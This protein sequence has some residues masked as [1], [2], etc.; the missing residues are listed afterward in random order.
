ML[1]QQ[2][3]DR[4]VVLKGL[5]PS[6]ALHRQTDHLLEEY[7]ARV[8]VTRFGF[9]RIQRCFQSSEFHLGHGE[10]DL[11]LGPELV[12]HRRLGD[13]DSIGDHLQRG[14]AHTVER[15][16]IQGRPDDPLLRGAVVFCPQLV[17]HD[18]TPRSHR[19]EA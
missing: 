5:H 8:S 12:V 14:A 17:L 6:A 3:D 18:V 16:E 9:R 10:H 1:A 13:A 11:L 7:G 19:T 4:G 15:E 2:P